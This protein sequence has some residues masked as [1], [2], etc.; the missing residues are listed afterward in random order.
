ML[1]FGEDIV[2]RIR[3]T[4]LAVL[5]VIGV[6]VGFSSNSEAAP[7]FEIQVSDGTSSVVIQDNLTGQDHDDGFGI[8]KWTGSVGDWDVQVRVA[9]TYDILGS[10]LAPEINLI[11]AN[12]SRA[13]GTLTIDVS[14]MGFLAPTAGF[15]PAQ[16]A[17]GGATLANRSGTITAQLF[18]GN[19]NVLL[20][21]TNFIVSTGPLMGNADGVFGG[22][23]IGGFGP[24]VG[25]FS[26]TSEVV[27]HHE[28]AGLTTFNVDSVTVPE[29]FTLLFLGSA[30]LGTAGL[31]RKAQK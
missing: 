26:L 1:K 18:G 3:K 8:I 5:L 11:S 15:T 31:A 21:K 6:L 24:T 29:P 23:A 4:A 9:Q 2:E 28:V 20:D 7:Y 25:N 17:I 13:A 22:S 19:S 12:N 16:I 14:A 27:V 10:V 30:L